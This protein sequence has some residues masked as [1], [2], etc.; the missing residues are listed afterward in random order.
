LGVFY[1]RAMESGTLR[2]GDPAPPFELR[3][4]NAEGMVSLAQLLAR[5]PAWLEFLR[6]TW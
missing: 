1:S 3:A 6:G 4:A 5:G 2:M